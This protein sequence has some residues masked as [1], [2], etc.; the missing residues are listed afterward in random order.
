MTRIPFSSDFNIH[1][2]LFAHAHKRKRSF[3]AEHG[4]IDRCHALI[5]NEFELHAL[6][7]QHLCHGNGAGAGNFFIVPEAKIHGA[8]RSFAFAQVH[9]GSLKAGNKLPLHIESAPAPQAILRNFGAKGR[10]T[11]AV[12]LRRNHILVPHKKRGL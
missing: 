1:P 9:F 2:A 4:S 7:T 11:P 12:F 3:D 10:K 6:L 8:R 5:K